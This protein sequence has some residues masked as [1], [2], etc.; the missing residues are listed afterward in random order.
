M[1]A[2]AARR[3]PLLRSRRGRQQERRHHARRRAASSAASRRVG[4]KL[5][6]EG[7]EETHSHLEFVA[8]H[9]QMFKA[10]VMVIADMGNVRTGEP[11]L[12]DDVARRSVRSR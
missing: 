7:E 9:P 12:T 2:H 3:R 1:G 11:V 5:I 6:I 4:I 8:R 10:D